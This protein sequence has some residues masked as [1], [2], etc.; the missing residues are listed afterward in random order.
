MRYE[1]EMLPILTDYLLN[2]MGYSIIINEFDSGYGIADIVATI[3][4]QEY[5]YYPFNNLIDVFLLNSIPYN[6]RILFE[7]IH[8]ISPYSEKYL[9]YVVLKGFIE[10]GLLIEDDI[11]YRRIKR[12]SVHKNPIVAIEAK[13]TKWKKAFFQA[14]RY[15]KYADFC[16]VAILE[17][18]LKN[19]DFDMF[20][21]HNIGLLVVTPSYFVYPV[22][23]AKRNNNKNTLFALYAN[24]VLF[25]NKN[26]MMICK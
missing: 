20:K 18:S 17:R 15:K 6:K 10:G 3:D 25:K 7:D 8:K 9:K 16:Y 4:S 24:G 5:D 22:I 19:V 2:N 21:E 23:K 26:C 14:I 12:L 1:K 11:G 13:L